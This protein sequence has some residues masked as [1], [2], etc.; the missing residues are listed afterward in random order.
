MM[1]KHPPLRT[2][3]TREGQPYVDEPIEVRPRKEAMPSPIGMAVAA[4][5]GEDKPKVPQPITVG[6]ELVRLRWMRPDGKGGLTPK[7][8]NQGEKTWK[9]ISQA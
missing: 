9:L 4:A 1:A 5:F 8:L 7:N 3:V 2:R 6:Y